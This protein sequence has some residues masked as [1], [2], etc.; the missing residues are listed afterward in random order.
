MPFIVAGK[1]NNFYCLSRHR[2][3]LTDALTI[4]TTALT[5]AASNKVRVFLREHLS[6]TQAEMINISL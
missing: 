3:T 6:Q 1:V 5:R 4:V 2:L